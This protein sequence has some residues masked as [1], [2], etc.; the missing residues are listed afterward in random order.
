MDEEKGG[1]RVTDAEDWW[2]CVFV[3]DDPAAPKVDT[4]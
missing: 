1:D 3:V 4:E 2:I